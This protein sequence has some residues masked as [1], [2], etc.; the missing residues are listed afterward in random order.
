MDQAASLLMASGTSTVRNQVKTAQ[1]GSARVQ[2]FPPISMALEHPHLSLPGLLLPMITACGRQVQAS[3]SQE[4]NM[5]HATQ[6]NRTP[7]ISMLH[8]HNFQRR[9]KPA[10]GAKQRAPRPTQS[11]AMLTCPTSA[12]HVL[13]SQDT[14]SRRGR[15][16]TFICSYAAR[17]KR[18]EK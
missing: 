8:E 16:P 1:L 15:L 12:L 2:S 14:W 13:N 11:S 7:V 17:G 10:S 3:S 5:A 6:P 4:E 9:S 18:M